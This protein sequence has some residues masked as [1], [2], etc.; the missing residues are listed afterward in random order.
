MILSV[1]SYLNINVVTDDDNDVLWN[2][3]C[4]GRWL[5]VEHGYV[6]LITGIGGTV[7]RE[8]RCAG[9]VISLYH[10]LLDKKTHYD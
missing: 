4:K 6:H 7:E 10:I 3:S 8:D 5:D 1:L 9:F 2:V